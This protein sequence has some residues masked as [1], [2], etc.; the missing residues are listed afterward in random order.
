MPGVFRT[1]ADLLDTAERL[2]MGLNAN[3]ADLGHLNGSREKLAGMLEQMREL[4]LQQS[5]FT[6]SKQDSSRQLEQ[7]FRN[8]AK[9][10]T[11]L[12]KAVAEHY[13]SEN[14]KVVE[15][16]LKPFRSRRRPAAAPVT[17]PP[18]LE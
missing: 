5:V 1:Q 12:R 13:G 11:V 9:L 3:T 16:G 4:L 10:I 15:F 18:S 6:A 14:E 8:S 17:P 2:L 7:L